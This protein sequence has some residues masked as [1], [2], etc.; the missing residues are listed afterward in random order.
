MF[1]HISMLR[2]IS[3]LCADRQTPTTAV[4][5]TLNTVWLTLGQEPQEHAKHM[6]AITTCQ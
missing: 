3:L 4:P 5:H 6:E 1:A 2:F